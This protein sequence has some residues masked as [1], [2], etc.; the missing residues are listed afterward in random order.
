MHLYHEVISLTRSKTVPLDKQKE[1]LLNIVNEYCNERCPNNLVAGFLHEEHQRDIHY[2]LMISANELDSPHKHRL[3]KKAFEQVKKNAELNVLKHYPQLEQVPV[4]T[5]EKEGKGKYSNKEQQ[6]KQRT[7]Q[8]SHK[9]QLIERLRMIFESTTSPEHLFRQLADDKLELYTRGKHT[10]IKDIA[11][12]SKHRLVTLNL[13]DEFQ[14]VLVRLK[15]EPSSSP[16]QQAKGQTDTVKDI[17]KEATTGNFSGRD[18]RAKK[19]K[20][21]KQ[22]KADEKVADFADQTTVEKVAEVGKEWLAGDFS[23]SETRARNKQRKDSLD[24][25]KAKQASQPSDTKAPLSAKATAKEW[26]MGDFSEREKRAAKDFDT[27]QEIE[28]RKARLRKQRE[29]N[30]ASKAKQSPDKSPDNDV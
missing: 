1:C 15:L 21:K 2:H 5:K 12:D 29:T 25:W 19:A 20:W 24:Q 13:A 8:P 17:L 10:N 28:S 14:E 18:T 4:I 16:Y 27:Q 7:R 30:E 23:N 11:R 3:N 9:D 6:M 26:I 22:Q